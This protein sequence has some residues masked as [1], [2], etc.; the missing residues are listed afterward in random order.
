MPYGAKGGDTPAKDK[1]IE[2]VVNAIRRDHPHISKVSA[3]KIAKAQQ[4]RKR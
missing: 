2:K 3:I 4:A 1:K